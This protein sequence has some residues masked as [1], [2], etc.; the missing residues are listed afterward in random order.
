MFTSSSGSFTAGILFSTKS[1]LEQRN[2]SIILIG[3][4]SFAVIGRVISTA[5]LTKF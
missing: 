4:S 1:K 3:P 5:P 2:E